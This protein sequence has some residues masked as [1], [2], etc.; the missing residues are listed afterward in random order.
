MLG[1]GI[2]SAA[3]PM[4]LPKLAFPSGTKINVFRLDLRQHVVYEQY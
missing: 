1:D 3:V 4:E 2:V